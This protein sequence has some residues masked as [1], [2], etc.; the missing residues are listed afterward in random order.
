MMHVSE[1]G[2]EGYVIIIWNEIQSLMLVCFAMSES[3]VENHTLGLSTCQKDHVILVVALYDQDMSESR[4][5][6]A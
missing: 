5:N 3:P 4:A 1:P 6:L 2:F